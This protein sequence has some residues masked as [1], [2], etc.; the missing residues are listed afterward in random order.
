MKY[1][2]SIGTLTHKMDQNG[3][4]RET[5]IPDREIWFGDYSLTISQQ[6]AAAGSQQTLNRMIVVRNIP[7]LP[8]D[9]VLKI[10]DTVYQISN[11]NYDE[12]VNAFDIL[13]LSKHIGH[14][15]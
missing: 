5:F 15:R 11:A 9:Q 14:S 10:D 12:S 4:T 8:I 6:I 13:T 1:K 2:A 3:V 7:H